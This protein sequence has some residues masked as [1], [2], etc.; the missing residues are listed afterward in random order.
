MITL[1]F[2]YPIIMIILLLATTTVSSIGIPTNFTSSYEV[3]SNFQQKFTV[4]PS[5]NSYSNGE[6]VGIIVENALWGTPAI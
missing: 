5:I 4:E 6:T 1:K 2:R 3:K